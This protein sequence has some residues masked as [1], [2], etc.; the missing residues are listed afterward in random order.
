ML[1]DK[2]LLKEHLEVLASLFCLPVPEALDLRLD[3]NVEAPE[4]PTPLVVI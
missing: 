3:S 4:A 1:F 2:P